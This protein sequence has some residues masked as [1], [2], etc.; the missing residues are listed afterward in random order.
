MVP[1]VIPGLVAKLCGKSLHN[2]SRRE[3]HDQGDWERSPKH[4]PM[5]NHAC[6]YLSNCSSRKWQIPGG[7]NRLEYQ[8]N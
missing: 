1:G 4:L 7:A 8:L 3:E 5:E 2:A 6:Q